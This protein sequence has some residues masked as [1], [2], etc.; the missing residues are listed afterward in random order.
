MKE[1][2]KVIKTCGAKTRSGG[3][4]A[5]FPIAGKRRCRLHG[6]MS[7]GPKTDEGKQRIANAQLKHG[8][9][10][11][12]RSRR[13]EEMYYF[14]EIKRIVAEAKAAGIWPEHG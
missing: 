9:Y 3:L 6:G 7:T 10:V 11:N 8:W 14:S 1:S 4:C 12:Y 5:K 13:K 2:T